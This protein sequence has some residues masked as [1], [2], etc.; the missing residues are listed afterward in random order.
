MA[1]R[2]WSFRLSPPFCQSSYRGCRVLSIFVI[3]TRA[4][5]ET[6]EKFNFHLLF[7]LFFLE[8]SFH[9]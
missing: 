3:K 7:F 9:S 4:I 8:I 6:I 2:S 5:V 1:D